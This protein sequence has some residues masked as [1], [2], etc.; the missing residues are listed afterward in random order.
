MLTARTPVT[1]GGQ[2]LHL[3][4]FDVGDEIVDSAA[5]VDNLRFTNVAAGACDPGGERVSPVVSLDPVTD[6]GTTD[7]GPLLGGQ[8]GQQATD[9]QNVTLQIYPA[10]ETAPVQTLS[11][12]RSASTWAAQPDGLAPGDYWRASTR[13]TPRAT[14]A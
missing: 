12:G 9:S 2:T 5:F 1:P 10:G 11:V 4:V 6:G 3:S 8:A 14:S 7:N 13:Q